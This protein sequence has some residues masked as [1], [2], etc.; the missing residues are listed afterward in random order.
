[1]NILKFITFEVNLEKLFEQRKTKFKGERD[2]EVRK[3]NILVTKE[4]EG[5]QKS[6]VVRICGLWIF[7]V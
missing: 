1:M 4:N 6:Q 3:L 7:G 2:R 5:K